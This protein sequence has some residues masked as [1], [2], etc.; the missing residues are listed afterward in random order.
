MFEK[1]TNSEI[2]KEIDKKGFAVYTYIDPRELFLSIKKDYIHLI[3][4]MYWVFLWVSVVAGIIF[5]QGGGENLVYVGVFAILYGYIFLHMCVLL[6]GRTKLFLKNTSIIYTRQA[7]MLNKK[8]YT[9]ESDPDFLD[10]V[11]KLEETFHETPGGESLVLVR[12]QEL[13]KELFNK[14]KKSFT[15]APRGNSKGA[16]QILLFIALFN[17]IFLV[18]YYLG[19][20][21][22]F[23]FFLLYAGVVSLLLRTNITPEHRINN[24]LLSIQK[25]IDGMNTA[26]LALSGATEQFL[27][28]ENI[29]ISGAVEKYFPPFYRHM[30]RAIDEKKKLFILIDVSDFSGIIDTELLNTYLKNQFNTPLQLMIDLLSQ[31]HQKLEYEIKSTQ[32]LLESPSTEYSLS[33]NLQLKLRTLEHQ[34]HLVLSHIGQLK[35]SLL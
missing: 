8:I 27:K 31:T 35:T 14:V 33:G 29:N 6:Y 12:T 7:L 19:Y 15:Q 34:N 30:E 16:G 3:S 23:G 22:F 20:I 21:L 26:R 24:T 13:E 2:Q 18:I 32:K 9:D 4:L 11:T 1:Y 17:I 5:W 25:Y 28:Q 10:Q